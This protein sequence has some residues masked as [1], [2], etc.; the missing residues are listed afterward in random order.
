MAD[1]GLVTLTSKYAIWE[2]ARRL[3]AAL[4]S[5]GLTVFARIDHAANAA[6]VNLPLRP[7]EVVIFGNAKGG[8]PL[9]Q[10]RQTAGLDLPLK[11]LL[12]EDADGKARLTYNTPAWIAE[13]HSLG[14][15][16]ASASAAMAAMMDKLA[17]EVTE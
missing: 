16:S 5:R 3:D 11:I 15:S 10:D 6:S 1:D 2:T 7:T 9:M 4:A 14:A 17:H 13:R 8:T 12:W